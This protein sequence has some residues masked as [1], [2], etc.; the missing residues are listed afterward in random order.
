V[1]QTILRQVSIVACLAGLATALVFFLATWRGTPT[2]QWMP[3]LVAMVGGY[4]LVQLGQ[5]LWLKRAGR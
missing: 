4:E 1:T 5:S 3:M 2:P